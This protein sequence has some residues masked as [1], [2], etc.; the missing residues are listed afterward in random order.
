MRKVLIPTK[1]DA[2]AADTLRAQGYD[3]VQ[4]ADTPIGELVARHPETTAVIVR[5]EKVD[6]AI[7]D[8]LPN[9]RLV[10]RAGAG[11]NT[12]DIKHA[13]RQGVDVMNTPGAN[14]NAVAEEVVALILAAYRHVVRGDQ[15]TRAGGWEKKKLMGRELAGKTIGIVG[16]GNIGQLLVKRLNGFELTVLAYDPILSSRRAEELNVELCTLS[17]LF[18]RSDVVSLHLPETEETR[19]MINKTVLEQMKDGAMLVNCA[20]AG[21]VNEADLRSV[22]ATKSLIYCNDVYPKDEAGPKSVADVADIMLPH[23]GANTQEANFNAAKRA[24]DQLVGYFERGISTCVVNRGIPEGLSENYQLLAYYL[25][26]IARGYL[27]KGVQPRRIE[28]SFYGDLNQFENWLLGPVVLGLAS[29]FD[30]FFDYQQATDYLGEKGITH[31][32]RGADE[33]KGYGNSITIDLLEGKDQSFSSVSVRGTIAEGAIM[34]S[35][36][37]NF[38]RLYFEPTGH[39]VLVVYN[40]RPGM[41]AKITSVM[42]ANDVNIEDIRSPHDPRTGNSLAVLKVNKAVSDQAL[43]EILAHDGFVKAVY[44]QI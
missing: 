32:S 44:L 1:L 15:T 2:V 13:R 12:I 21:V 33:S 16:L 35:R 23:L 26:R 37:N 25:T 8:A 11:F 39:S 31:V 9:L 6:Q 29:N 34:V 24:A 18:G 27:G 42:A 7:L 20:R 5:S 14:A 41:L 19:G 28:T 17:D 10:V 43:G 38:D 4:D 36:I 30:P 40:D 3:V 22:K